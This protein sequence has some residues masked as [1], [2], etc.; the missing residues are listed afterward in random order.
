MLWRRA[1]SCDV[2]GRLVLGGTMIGSFLYAPRPR[3]DDIAVWLRRDPHAVARLMLPEGME[4][5]LDERDYPPPAP[6]MSVESALS[7]GIF[8]AIRCHFSLVIAGDRSAWNPDWGHLTDLGR[9]PNA[10]LV[11]QGGARSPE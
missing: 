1:P 9:F 3:P 10:G 7:Y 6:I 2:G 11:A 4:K 5:L 8:L